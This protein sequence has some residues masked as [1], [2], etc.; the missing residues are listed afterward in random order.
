M[1]TFVGVVEVEDFLGLGQ[2]LAVVQTNDVGH[3]EGTLQFGQLTVHIITTQFTGLNGY[4]ERRNDIK[5]HRQY[6]NPAK[7]FTTP[8]KLW[9]SQA[10]QVRRGVKK[11]TA[12][13]F[14]A[15]HT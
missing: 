14:V 15:R 8:K 4:V 1:L 11:E 9:S 6:W 13:C 2:Y 5:Q 10:G 12:V 3:L 7:T